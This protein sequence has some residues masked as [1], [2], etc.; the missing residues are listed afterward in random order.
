MGTLQRIAFFLADL[1]LL[2]FSLWLSYAWTGGDVWGADRA[3]S[4]YLIIFSNLTWLF[5][6]VVANPYAV[7]RNWGMK[8]ILR[9]QL[10][11]VLVHLLV[12]AGLIALLG[13][14][15]RPGQLV[16]LYAVFVISFILWKWLMLF[17]S[18][19]WLERDKSVRRYILVGDAALAR[20][21]RRYFRV[22]T[23][24]GY[25][26][27][28]FFPW[29]DGD[30][31]LEPIKKYCNAHPVDELFCCLPH[32]THSALRNVIDF[33]MNELIKI[34]LISDHHSFEQRTLALGRYDQVPVFD[35]S[36]IPLDS[37]RNLRIKRAFDLFFS[38]LVAVF[39]LSWMIP[40]IGLIIKLDS[41]G[42]VFF[43]QRRSGRSN[44]PFF[45]LKFRTMVVNTEADS[46]QAS[47]DDPRVT[48]V[49]AFLRKTSLD[50]FPQFINVLRGEMS[51]VGPRPHPIKLNEKF[52]PLIHKY[53]IRHYVKPGVTGLA[54]VMGYRGETRLIRD[55]RNRITLD[56]FYIEN[57]S[58]Y[59]DVKI[60]L[61]TIWSVVRGSE[62]AY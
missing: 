60:I 11:Y 51:V 28:G 40:L 21:V 13:K 59:F 9:S 23:D 5:L 39:V 42:P 55:M 25:R 18:S 62:K 32:A 43:S 6:T 37:A 16:I 61:M 56:R 19:L 44:R 47:L 49:G 24:L 10:G 12:V 31:S 29:S 1:T 30:T 35:I 4:V 46:R 54:Q 53:M 58:F 2:N 27:C 20:E 22:H 3:D 7:S 38:L 41:P 36:T 33:G 50:E 57:W 45:C 52:R 26:F 34:K 14:H 17:G 48:R 8:K 15:Y